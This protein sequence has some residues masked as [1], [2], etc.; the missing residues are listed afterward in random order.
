MIHVDGSLMKMRR[1]QIFT[2]DDVAIIRFVVDLCG[3]RWHAAEVRPR[4]PVVIPENFS[5]HRRG[6]LLVSLVLF[7]RAWS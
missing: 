6:G 2:V 3:K 1:G 7:S 5:C 4:R